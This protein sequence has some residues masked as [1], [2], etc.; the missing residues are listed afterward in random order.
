MGGE[1]GTDEEM[2]DFHDHGEL[3][4]KEMYPYQERPKSVQLNVAS[5]IV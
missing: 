5:D 1:H 2:H 3:L 4:R